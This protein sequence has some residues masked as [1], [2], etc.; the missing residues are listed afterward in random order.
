MTRLRFGWLSLLAATAAGT[1]AGLAYAAGHAQLMGGL[2]DE[3]RAA[4]RE[5]RFWLRRVDFIGLDSLRAA[6]LWSLAGVEHGT[7]LI[8]LDTTRLSGAVAAH[9][10]VASCR[11]VRLPPDRL[12]VE[13][14]E[15]VP[16]ARDAQRGEGI[17]ASGERFPLLPGEGEALPRLEGMTVLALPLLLAARA[18]GV[19][20]EAVDA[21]PGDLR[22]RP[23]GSSALVRLGNDAERSLHT[24]QRVRASGLVEAYGAAEV[25]L[26]F[27][28]DAVLR[29]IRRKG[30]G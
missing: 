25:D 29:G 10:R 7:P 16:I 14:E 2:R 18:H 13:V 22:I 8:D 17:D 23:A 5:P 26:R 21:R 30:G 12:V 27:P 24:W 11:A 20:L 19:A 1:V 28:G 3:L 15:R 6:E 9:P 4:L